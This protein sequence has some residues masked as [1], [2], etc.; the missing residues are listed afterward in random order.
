MLSQDV[1]IGSAV[2]L[3]GKIYFCIDF[4]HVK[5][6]KG[7]TIMRIKLKDVLTADSAVF[8]VSGNLP[9]TVY[10]GTD[11]CT[12]VQWLDAGG[13]VYWTGPEIGRY[14]SSQDGIRDLGK[15]LFNGMVCEDDVYG[16]NH[17]QMYEY[18]K[19]R[20]DDCLYGLSSDVPDSLPLGY[21]TDDGHS[22][23][24]VAKLKASSVTVFGGNVAVTDNVSQVLTDRTFCAEIVVSGL[25]YGSKGLEHGEGTLNGNAEIV[26]K[27]DPS[28]YDAV[29]LSVFAGEPASRWGKTLEL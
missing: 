9:D 11:S 3:D 20:Y 24:T 22:A 15:G 14:I 27:A 25:T 16:Y 8:F 2:R 23:V 19:I 6:G 26:I 12:F 28:A 17:S 4:Q 18:T 29:S 13:R 21:V 10:D 5:P 1:K 7:N